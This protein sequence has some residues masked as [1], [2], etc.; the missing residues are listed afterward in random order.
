MSEL[1]Y[2]R[3]MASYMLTEEEQ[4]Q[5][6]KLRLLTILRTYCRLTGLNVTTDYRDV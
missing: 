5:K 1:A 3:F 2:S 4:L 6:I